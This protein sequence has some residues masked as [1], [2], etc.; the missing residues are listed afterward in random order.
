MGFGRWADF[1][2]SHPWPIILLAM[3]AVGLITPQ[4]RFIEVSTNTDEFLMPDHPIRIAYN[5]FREQF[6]SDN[7]VLITIEHEQI[8]SQDFLTWLSS[9]HDALEEN[10]PYVDEITSLVNVRTTRG[11]GEELLVDDLLEEW[12]EDATALARVEQIVS[13]TPFH[14]RMVIGDGA[15]HTSIQIELVGFVEEATADLDFSGFDENDSVEEDAPGTGRERRGLGGIEEERVMAAVFEVLAQFDREDTEVIV[16][17]T[18]YVN[19]RIFQDM[20]QNMLIFIL[21]SIGAVGVVLGFVFRR[22]SG[23]VL[24]L[25]VVLASIVTTFGFIGLRGES[26]NMTVQVVPSFLLAVGSSSSIHL[27]VLFY[28]SFDA[29]HSRAESLRNAMTH[30]GMPIVLACATTAAGLLSFLIADMAP[31]RDIGFMA[32][33]GIATGLVLCLS[34]LPALLSVVPLSRRPLVDESRPSRASRGL[35]AIGDFA[36]M[37]PI[38]VL[39]VTGI[40][41]VVALL[42]FS[43]VTF[44]QN[45]LEWFPDDDPIRRNIAITDTYMGG[46]SSIELLLDTGRENGLHEPEFQRRLDE[47]ETRLTTTGPDQANIRKTISVNGVLKEIHQALNANDPDFYATPDDRALIAQELLLFENSGSDDLDKMVDSQF[48]VARVSI[49][50]IWGNGA[51]NTALLSR[52][53]AAAEQAFPDAEIQATGLVPIIMTALVEGEI[54]MRNSYALAILTITPLMVLLIGS[55]RGGLS[56]MVP[57]L[58]P[59]IIVIGLMGW[60]RVPFDVFTMMT[61]S[62]AIGLAVDD[63]IHFLHS[64]YR[65]F[66]RTRNTRASV[67]HTLETTGQALLTT[68]I[69]LG[70]GFGVFLFASMPSLVTFGLATTLAIVLAFLADIVVAPALVTLATRHRDLHRPDA[71]G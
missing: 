40:V 14:Q 51:F 47:F 60:L 8:F 48:Q 71:I 42:G 13:E 55:V 37:H 3:V 50:T 15:R 59:I 43:R 27:L 20:G 52:T 29:G 25:G 32:P 10:V 67:R 33:V 62:V 35:V 9:L 34:L 31:V 39:G 26:V 54:G 38:P 45:A 2:G 30:A 23:I 7:Y 44:E 16:A 17:G 24:P 36:V 41:V 19:V 58:A 6:G 1:V 18:P 56:S 22:F 65:E 46:T 64:F 63:T 70:V 69:V 12:P 4:A 57:N 21:L 66:E 68:S 53:E 11:E 61:G 28:Q 5:D 49:R